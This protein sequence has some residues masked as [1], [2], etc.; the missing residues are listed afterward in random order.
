MLW[1]HNKSTCKPMP[2]VD[3][4]VGEGVMLFILILEIVIALSMTPSRLARL[5][6]FPEVCSM[7]V[8]FCCRS[9]LIVLS[10]LTLAGCNKK[11][12][13]TLDQY[14]NMQIKYRTQR[15]KKAGAAMMAKC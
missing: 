1:T 15:T 9:S 13:Y 6:A 2:S 12:T 8:S 4:E 5:S 3:K 11:D 7:L 14:K 10:G